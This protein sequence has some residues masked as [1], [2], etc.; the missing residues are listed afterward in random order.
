MNYIIANGELYH[1]GIK[2][3]KWGVRRYQNADGSLTAAGQ[4]RYGSIAEAYDISKSASDYAKSRANEIRNNKN[5]LEKRYAGKQGEMKY[6]EDTYGKNWEKNTSK[7]VADSERKNARSN[8]DEGFKMLDQA[9]NT[10]ESLAKEYMS[11]SERFNKT[12]VKDISRSD[13]KSAKELVEAFNRAGRK[14]E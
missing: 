4:K 10:Y 13:I 6:L 14:F 3:Q 1:H 5:K 11:K 2:G 7:K 9:I 8:I 12:S